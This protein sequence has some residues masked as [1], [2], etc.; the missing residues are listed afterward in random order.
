MASPIPFTRGVP[1]ASLLPVDDIARAAAAALADDPAGALSYSY[2]GYPPLREWIAARHG[3]DA[4]RVL[5]VNGS[6]QGVNFVA[7]HCLAAAGATAVVEQP[8]YDR[9]LLVL[10]AR[11]RLVPLEVDGE[12]AD[13]DALAAL[14]RSGE[15]PGLVYLIPTFQN[16]SGTTLSLERRRA[17]VEL[18][19][20]HEL[21]VLEDDP[22]SL[23]RYEGEPLPSLHELDGGE[24]VVYSS[25]FTKTV[26]PGV[27]TGYLVLPERL[28]EPFARISANTCIS[29]NSLAEA[30]VAAYCAAGRFEPNLAAAVAELHRRRD[31][32][33][34]ALRAHF[35]AGSRWLRPAGGYFFW[36]ALPSGLD[37]RDLLAEAAAEGVAY[38]SGDDFC[39]EGGRRSLRLA[40]SACSVADIE[41]GVERLGRLLCRRLE[42]PAA[43]APA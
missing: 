11:A 35:P 29:P 3:V 16:P 4:R 31:A 28:V 37:A 19:Q 15:A 43:A 5:L 9:S 32:M 26:A 12:G 27:R 20:R 39:V 41:D 14:L 25:S 36:V 10:G 7:Q 34:A 30:T 21:L 24:H 18:A 17:L 23:L 6:L 22:Y 13:V 40:F 38:L 1:D 2:G 8:T 42:R 33:E